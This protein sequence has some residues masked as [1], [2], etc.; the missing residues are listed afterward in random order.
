MKFSVQALREEIQSRI[1]D[2]Q[3]VYAV[4]EQEDREL[5]ADEQSRIDA[6]LAEIGNPTRGDV[7]ATGLYAQLER[8]ERHETMRADIA[9]RRNGPAELQS[10]PASPRF[11]VPE[12][13]RWLSRGSLRAFRGPTAEAEAYLTGQFLAAALFQVPASLQWCADHGVRVYN[14]LS[15]SDNALGGFLVPIEMERAIITLREERGVFRREA[16]VV[17][18]GSDTL[19][20]PRR[21]TGVTAYFAADNGAMTASDKAWDDVALVAKKVYALVKYSSELAE[22]AIISI[23]DDLTAEIAYAFADKED[24]CGINGNGTSTYGGIVGVLNAMNAGSIYTAASGNTAFATLDLADFEGALGKVPQYA[25]G[26]AKWYISRV[27]FYQSIA[28]LVD[29]L[30]GNTVDH[31]AS[32]P[33]RT[34]FL[35]LPVVFSQVLNS[36]TTAQ[37]STN[38]LFVGDLKQGA[39]LGTRRGVSILV[40]EHRYFEYDQLAIRG[41]ERFDINVHEKGTASAASSLIVL[42][43][44]SS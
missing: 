22:D 44:P 5:T 32:G 27:G 15:G 17:P 13:A 42:A 18:M 29:A 8:M 4:A 39:M 14:A 11:E 20:V 43:T 28:R 3:A 36:T 10:T 30:G 21:T 1:D 9:N 38:I 41:T 37:A 25:V 16:R 24:E 2:T 19:N 6:A 40:S 31:A 12:A 26:N 7:P 34:Q 33:N 23:G 35:G